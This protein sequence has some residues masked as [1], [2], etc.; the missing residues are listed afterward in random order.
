MTFDERK[1]AT[2]AVIAWI[3]EALG[4]Q[5]ADTW[6]W[7]ATPMPCGLPSDEQLDEGLRV[8]TGELRMSDLLDR[9]YAEMAEAAAEC[10]SAERKDSGG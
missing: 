9:V 1:D 4:D 6:A 8:A 10:M 2:R 3:V 5:A 7:E